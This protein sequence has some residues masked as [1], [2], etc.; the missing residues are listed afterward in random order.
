MGQRSK[1]NQEDKILKEQVQMVDPPNWEAIA[2]S[3]RFRGFLKSSKQCRAR[4]THQLHPSLKKSK[5]TEEESKRLLEIHQKYGSHWKNISYEFPGRT[6]NFLKNQFFSLIRRSLRRIGKYLK[7]PKSMLTVNEIKPK[8]L[9]H[10]LSLDSVLKGRVFF[11]GK[12]QTIQEFISIFCFE[13][14]CFWFF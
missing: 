4:W 7:I 5:W 2:E 8:M 9:S 6:D 1:P 14:Y 10:F 3:L 12:D 11:R 13:R